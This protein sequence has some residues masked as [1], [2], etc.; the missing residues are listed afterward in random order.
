[1]S[2]S[3]PWRPPSERGQEPRRRRPASPL[4][5]APLACKVLLL[6]NSSEQ[7]IIFRLFPCS[8][9]ISGGCA[10]GEVPPSVAANSSPALHRLHRPTRGL[11]TRPAPADHEPRSRSLTQPLPRLPRPPRGLPTTPTPVDHEPWSLTPP[12]PAMQ[13]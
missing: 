1:M 7:L 13:G 9:L 6:A 4:Q 11:P 5:M 3:W 2:C 8:F 10:A 12:P